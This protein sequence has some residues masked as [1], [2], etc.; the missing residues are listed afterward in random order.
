MPLD[1]L[2]VYSQALKVHNHK[3]NS[4]VHPGAV[5]REKKSVDVGEEQV[6]ED[7]DNDGKPAQ[8]NTK[9]DSVSELGQTILANDV[10]LD[11]A[12]MKFLIS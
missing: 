11:C 7:G 3:S 4:L 8:N 9:D 5:F 12:V 2:Q 10:S 6:M 1:R